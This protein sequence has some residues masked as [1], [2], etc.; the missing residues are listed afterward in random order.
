LALLGVGCGANS[1][2]NPSGAAG[3]ASSGGSGSSAGGSAAGVAGS[4]S[5]VGGAQSGEGGAQSGEGGAQSGEGGDAGNPNG[6]ECAAL[7]VSWRRDGG[8]VATQAQSSIKPCNTFH[9]ETG[10]NGGEPTATC[11]SLLQKCNLG[12]PVNVPQLN[13]ALADA[14]V[15]A[16]IAAAPVL[17]GG[18]TRPVDGSVRRID[19][20][21]QVVDVGNDCAAGASCDPIPEGVAAL[22]DLLWTIER[23]QLS[24]GACELQP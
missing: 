12:L 16:A 8:H 3:G 22:A 11:N 18:D 2:P 14:D 13:S 10:P 19:I 9:H 5:S 6:C 4:G 20:D 24:F 15:Q 21:G 1:N 23:Q 17:Y 7:P